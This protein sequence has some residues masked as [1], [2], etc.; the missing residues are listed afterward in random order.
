MAA[1]PWIASL[2]P[3]E[4]CAAVLLLLLLLL[5]LQQQQ[6]QQQQQITF[7]MLWPLVTMNYGSQ[8]VNIFSVTSRMLCCCCCSSRSSSS[9]SRSS[10]SRSSINRIWYIW[11]ILTISSHISKP[12]RLDIE[13]NMFVDN[14]PSIVATF[15]HNCWQWCI[16]WLVA[17]F[18]YHPVLRPGQHDPQPKRTDSLSPLLHISEGESMT[19]ES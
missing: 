17:E 10:S 14:S 13:L 1:R 11:A 5:L 15:I 18:W 16:H 12:S 8:A 6:Q 7:K 9:N 2:W 3:Q 4:F 19:L